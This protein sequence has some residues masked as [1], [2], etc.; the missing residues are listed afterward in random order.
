[1]AMIKFSSKEEMDAALS[2]MNKAVV[3]GVVIEE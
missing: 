2:N 3:V 1:M